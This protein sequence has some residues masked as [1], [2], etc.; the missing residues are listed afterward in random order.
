MKRTYIL[1]ARDE[2]WVTLTMVGRNTELDGLPAGVAFNSSSIL[3]IDV[4]EGGVTEIRVL[5]ARD[6]NTSAIQ[7]RHNEGDK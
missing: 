3:A 4:D 6:G 7:L 5:K 2:N 1:A